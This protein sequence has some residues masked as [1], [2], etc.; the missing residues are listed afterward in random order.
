MVCQPVRGDSRRA[1]ANGLSPVQVENHEFYTTY[2]SV[3]FA[4]YDIFR[5]NV[6]KTALIMIIEGLI[7]GDVNYFFH[8]HDPFRRLTRENCPQNICSCTVNV[9]CTKQ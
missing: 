9:T 6:G 3:D 2:I 7:Y 1:L 4:H 8:A 5:S